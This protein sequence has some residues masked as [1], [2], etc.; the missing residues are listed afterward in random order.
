MLLHVY[1]IDLVDDLFA[2]LGT[3]PVEHDVIVTN[4]SGQRLNLPATFP[5]LTGRV[6]V[7]DVENRGRDI[8]PMIR[9]INA[10]MLDGYELVLKLHTKKSA[11]RDS[12]R[13]ASG[14]GAEWRDSFLSSLA[15]SSDAVASILASFASDRDLGIVT[16][17][18]SLLDANWWGGN[19]PTA[20]E[21]LKRIE[22]QLVKGDLLFPAGSMYWVRGFVL[23]GLRSLALTPDDFE[24]EDGQVNATTAH[25]VE[26]LIGYLA[27]EAGFDQRTTDF[28]PPHTYG[29]TK[30]RAD[31]ERRSRARVFPFYLPQFHTFP[32]N[33]AWWG[34]GFTEWTN[35][36]AA[37]PVFSGHRQPLL[38]S[39]SGFYDLRTPGVLDNQFDLAASYG[40]EGFMFYYYWFA[41]ERLMDF[42]V[43]SIVANDKDQPFCLMWANENWTRTWDGGDKDILIGQDYDTVPAT[44][45]IDDVMHLITNPH[46]MTIDGKPLIAVYRPGQMVDFAGVVKVWRERAEV[47]GLPGLVVFSVDVGAAMDGHYGDPAAL[48]LD[49]SMDFPPHNHYWRRQPSNRP[50][51]DPRFKGQI[52]SYQDMADEAI[53]TLERGDIDST[54]CP[55]VL[56]NFDNTARRQWT[57]DIW[58]G[59]NPFTFRRWL[60]AAVAAVQSRPDES[61]IVFINAWNEWAESAVL[62]PSAAFGRTYLQAV[63]SVLRA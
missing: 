63:D 15:G 27:A 50:R 58:Y 19:T 47:A 25:A 11:W 1:F 37:R 43:E 14:T 28:L 35:V 53:D 12:H 13:D 56:V 46:Y 41:G 48:G 31:T 16:S 18:G 5:P 2:A 30:F 7:I 24:P 22:L 9:V 45:F 54:H 57:S 62:E 10:D 20:R 26:R 60:G 8:L 51:V 21:I 52:V 29:H 4:A 23:Q 34:K 32:E 59:A 49:G 61:R 6:T 39:E 17:P 38:P 3:I 42:P 33:D 36:T 40:I 55:G 44:Q